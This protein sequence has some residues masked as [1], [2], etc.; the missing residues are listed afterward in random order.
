MFFVYEWFCLFISGGTGYSLL[1][2]LFS[3]S[4]DRG[5]PHGGAWAPHCAGFSCCETQA[6]GSWASVVEAPGLQS[7]GSVA[8]ARGLRCSVACR[9]SWTRDQTPV[10]HAGR[11]ILYHSAT[12]EALAYSFMISF[13]LSSQTSD[14]H[15]GLPHQDLCSFR[16]QSSYLLFQSWWHI[17]GYLKNDP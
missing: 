4:Y 11:R 13:G 3:S 12:G 7:T 1:R 2:G 17:V 15:T 9:V 6:P 16:T 5:S 10:P 8:V 14:A